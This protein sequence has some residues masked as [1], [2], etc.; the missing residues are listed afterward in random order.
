MGSHC[1]YTR[2]KSCS[3]TMC[4]I[5]SRCPKTRTSS[6]QVGNHLWTDRLVPL[7]RE[8][9]RV[10]LLVMYS[11]SWVRVA[12]FCQHNRLFLH[13]QMEL[14]SSKLVP[15]L[16]LRLQSF[17]MNSN[18]RTPAVTRFLRKYVTKMQARLLNFHQRPRLQIP[19][20]II[21]RITIEN[22][23]TFWQTLTRNQVL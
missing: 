6:L 16:L 2:R 14:P 18:L 15:N 19:F 8:F 3:S 10:H 5:L 11:F 23:L 20:Y 7:R 17:W 13:F 21:L 9:G 4:R 22:L 12:K 1:R